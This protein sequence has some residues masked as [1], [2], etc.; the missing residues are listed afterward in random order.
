[1]SILNDLDA[2]FAEQIVKNVLSVLNDI[3][4][5]S[6]YIGFDKVIE[7]N[8]PNAPVILASNHSGRAIPWDAVCFMSGLLEQFD[9]DYKKVCKTLIVPILSSMGVM[10]P[11]FVT[12]FWKKCG[13][14]DATFA[15]FET[16]MKYADTN[17]MLYPEGVPGIGKGFNHKYELQ[18][19]STSFIRMSLKYDTDIVP[20][21]TVNAEYINP[22]MYNSK[23]VNRLVKALTGIP[24]LPLGLLTIMLLLQPWFYYFAFP[25]KMTFVKGKRIRRDKLTQKQY[26]ELSD[27]EIEAIRDKV[28]KQMQQELTE[29]VQQY[30]KRPYEW[31]E[32]FRTAWKQRKYFPYYLPPFWTFLFSEFQVQW[33]KDRDVQ[34]KY[35]FW[36]ILKLFWKRPIVIAYFIPILGWL[37]ILYWSYLGK[38]KEAAVS[39]ILEMDVGD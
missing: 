2:Q 23:I 27:S 1:M 24:F 13:G 4:F 15:N 25:A 22:F 34:I 30:G 7:R 31:K 12:S 3:Y 32:F 26:D 37:P 36:T 5:R 16:L 6:I 28:H 39:D 8:N 11:F 20:Y 10:V 19:L 35:N 17:V 21:A 29:A 33:E 38:H 14:V 9:Y 18:R